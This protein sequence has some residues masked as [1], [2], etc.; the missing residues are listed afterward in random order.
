MG[1]VEKIFWKQKLGSFFFLPKLPII[2][3][4]AYLLRKCIWKIIMS[5]LVCENK[6][7]WIF[8]KYNFSW[9]LLIWHF[10]FGF[11]Q[12]W[13]ERLIRISIIKN[14]FF[15][16]FFIF[17]LKKKS[18]CKFFLFWIIFLKWYTSLIVVLAQEMLICFGEVDFNF[19][20]LG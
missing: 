4:K 19:F 9:T 14:S 17:S 3:R 11:T 6:S 13:C 8:F 5:M 16:S 2:E 15:F 10:F 18:D 12:I 7:E 1:K 20:R